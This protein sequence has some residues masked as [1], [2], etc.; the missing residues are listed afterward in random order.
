[1][2]G[3]D[4][5]TVLARVSD[6]AGRARTA[7]LEAADAGDRA[8]VLKAGDSELR[9][10]GILTA[11]GETSEQE[12]ALRS[13]FR[14]IAAAVIRLAR[15]DAAAAE[16][17]AAELDRMHRSAIAADIREQYPESRIENRP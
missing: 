16:P 5:T 8:A 2:L 11:N 1:M 9:A 6:I 17:V 7:A 15:H 3:L 4:H 12:I 14:D 13:M 10:L